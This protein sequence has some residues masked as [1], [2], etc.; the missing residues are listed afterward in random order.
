MKS[1]NTYTTLKNKKSKAILDA[2]KINPV[3]LDGDRVIG[4]ED[5]KKSLN[6]LKPWL[7]QAK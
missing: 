3:N 5:E 7:K 2:T 1:I 6:K 4:Q